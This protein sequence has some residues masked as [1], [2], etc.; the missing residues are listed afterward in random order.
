MYL[1][2]WLIHGLIFRWRATRLRKD[3][4]EGALGRAGQAIRDAISA[5]TRRAP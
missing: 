5:L 3:S 2:V 4:V 1:I